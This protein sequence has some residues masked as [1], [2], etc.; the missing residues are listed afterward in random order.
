MNAVPEWL[1]AACG[2]QALVSLCVAMAAGCSASHSASSRGDEAT[3]PPAADCRCFTEPASGWAWETT[4]PLASWTAGDLDGDGG[5]DLLVLLWPREPLVATVFYSRSG[6][7]D[8]EPSTLV[9]ATSSGSIV[10]SGDVD[11]DGRADVAIASQDPERVAVYLSRREFAAGEPQTILLPPEVAAD[12]VVLTDVNGDGFADLLVGGAEG[13]FARP[14]SAFAYLG[15]AMGLGAGPD[16]ERRGIGT[17]YNRPQANIVGA[18]DLNADGLSDILIAGWAPGLARTVEIFLGLPEGLSPEPAWSADAREV[19]MVWGHSAASAGDVNQ[20]G[21]DDLILLG[22][23]AETWGDRPTSYRRAMIYGAADGLASERPTWLGDVGFSMPGSAGDVNGDGYADVALSISSGT[24][25]GSDLEIELH[26]G[27]REGLTTRVGA[28]I[29]GDS[30]VAVGD[31]NDDG[32]D[33]FAVLCVRER[34]HQIR[35]IL[36]QSDFFP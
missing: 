12:N 4:D 24:I 13:G 31:V 30:A 15:S 8:D 20:D 21:F 5:T 33:D 16:W 2:R 9:E 34:R 26:A 28:V 19:D 3:C 7:F 14:V 35:L 25:P 27:S 1:R 36:G 18:G 22:A 32:Y 6:R 23:D 17:A 11:G 29:E 10:A